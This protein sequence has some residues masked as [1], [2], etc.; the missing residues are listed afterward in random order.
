M[1]PTLAIVSGVL[2]GLYALGI[3][4]ALCAPARQPD[5]QRGVAQGC[6]GLVLVA[7]AG[8]GLLLGLAVRFHLTVVIYVIAAGCI[9]PAVLL[10]GN[11]AWRLVLRLTAKRPPDNEPPGPADHNT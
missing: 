10:A 1:A 11:L 9:Y 8:V 5:P 2:L 6:L 3:G 4:Y 7:L